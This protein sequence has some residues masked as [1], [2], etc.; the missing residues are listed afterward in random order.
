[1]DGHSGKCPTNSFAKVSADK[2][3][4]KNVSIE[5]RSGEDDKIEET[6]RI[7]HG[8]LEFTVTHSDSLC[9]R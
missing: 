1:M 6:R 5:T 3:F 9:N 4:S 7:A 2:V 8:S